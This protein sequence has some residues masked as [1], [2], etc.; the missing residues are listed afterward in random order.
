MSK[1]GYF[2]SITTD[3]GSPRTA[4]ITVYNAGTVVL[5][6][7]WADAAGTIVKDNPFTTD[8][9]GRFQFFAT[10][11]NYDVQVSGSGIT[12][13]K[14]E[15][16]PL[17][18][19]GLTEGD[20]PTFAGLNLTGLLT[21]NVLGAAD[22]PTIQVLLKNAQDIVG[23]GNDYE[24]EVHIRLQAGSTADHREY[25]NFANYAGVDKWLTGRNASNVWILYSTQDVHRLW[26]EPTSGA[27]T[28]GDS[29]IGSAGAGSV[30]INSPRPND[31][32]GT[33]G[34][35]VYSGGAVVDNELLFQFSKVAGAY[36]TDAVFTDLVTLGAVF[37]L[38]RPVDWQLANSLFSYSTAGDAKQNLGLHARHD[39]VLAC[40]GT[41]WARLYYDGG[42]HLKTLLTMGT[43]GGYVRKMAEASAAITANHTITITLSIPAGS[44]ILGTQ[45]RVESALAAGETWNA[46]YVG[47]NV[48]TIAHEEA[49]AI[50]TKIYVPWG[51]LDTGGTLAAQAAW[52]VDLTTAT[53]NI[54]I[55]KHSN[56]GVDAFTAQGEIRAIVYYEPMSAMANH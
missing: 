37:N 9:L 48:A 22:A 36:T 44:R 52:A 45:L 29:C 43:T 3:V 11:G 31:E 15:N 1:V 6:S 39:L 30:A 12:T 34:L 32:N 53:T 28:S 42:F 25:I 21:V 24:N 35:E 55:Q 40:A 14:I 4:T 49:V 19:T 46:Q 50:N 5:A 23:V 13:Y 8:V 56:P 18:T 7:I 33:G 16:Q 27:F 17:G 2:N 10:A 38:A 26:F 51:G 54:T 20:T 47:G 41:E